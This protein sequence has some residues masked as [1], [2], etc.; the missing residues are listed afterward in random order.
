MDNVSTLLVSLARKALAMFQTK[1][2]PKLS[3][4]TTGSLKR[5]RSSEWSVAWGLVRHKVTD[6]DTSEWDGRSDN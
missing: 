4:T 2:D 5:R 3:T 6:S 1:S